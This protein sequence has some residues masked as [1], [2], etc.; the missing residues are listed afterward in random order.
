[1]DTDFHQYD[2]ER[3]ACGIGAV[4]NIDGRRDHRTVSDALRIAERLD[5]RAGKDAEGA[6]GDGVGILTQLPHE[7]FAARFTEDGLRKAYYTDPK[8]DAVLMS[9]ELGR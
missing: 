3:D 7:F 8:E 1:M 5:H 9:R 6:V 2:R 4:V